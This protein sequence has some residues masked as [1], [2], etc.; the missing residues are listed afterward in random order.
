M[1]LDIQR[2]Q[3]PVPNSY[4][5][6]FPRA[7]SPGS[8]WEDRNDRHHCGVDIYAPIGSK[9]VAI[10]S[11]RVLDVGV[12]TSPS[13]YD[14]WNVSYYV[15]IKSDENIVYKY[16]GLENVLLKPGNTVNSGDEIG[17]VAAAINTDRVSSKDPFY[18]RE[19]IYKN[20]PSMLHLEI[21]KAPIIEIRPY[22]GG[23]FL[24]NYKPQSL[25][26]P[27]AFLV[28]VTKN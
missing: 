11:G 16:A 17:V 9:V 1:S 6:E 15:I 27:N 4:E 28:G 25:L 26:D 23:N 18:I 7:G 8:F 13:G 14:F 22:L 21:Y 2:K 20:Q 12:F 24:G 3:W 10:D 5:N 19:L